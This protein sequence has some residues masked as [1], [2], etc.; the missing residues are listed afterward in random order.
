[1]KVYLN[2]PIKSYSGV[3][4]LSKRSGTTLVVGLSLLVGILGLSYLPKICG[5]QAPM[6]PYARP[7]CSKVKKMVRRVRSVSSYLKLGGQLPTLPTRQ[8]RP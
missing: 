2:Q 6:L 4:W 8:L 5:E 7:Y 3:T 1:M